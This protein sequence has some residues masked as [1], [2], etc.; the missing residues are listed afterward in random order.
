[1]QEITLGENTYRIGQ[2]NAI[3]QFHLSRKLAPLLVAASPAALAMSG[4]QVLPAD[5]E[6]LLAPAVDKIAELDDDTAE[7]VLAATL[8]VVSRQQGNGW[9]NVW[10]QNAGV[11]MFS[12]I[13][14]ETLLRLVY[15]VIADN[16]G[17]FINGLVS[18]LDRPEPEPEAP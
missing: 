17:P 5:L 8:G 14:L 11:L 3:A 16:L 13:G 12:D 7:A 18:G 10:D 1:V 15:A 6:A 2:L 4:S 9:A